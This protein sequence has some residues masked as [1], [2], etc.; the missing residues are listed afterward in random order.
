MLLPGHASSSRD[1]AA[2]P[3]RSGK[4]CRRGQAVD[5]AA[6]GIG[7]SMLTEAPVGAKLTAVALFIDEA[8]A[9]ARACPAPAGVWTCLVQG[10]AVGRIVGE[11]RVLDGLW[12]CG[13]AKVP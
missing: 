9:Q 5:D 10:A 2:A 7:S 6:N 13:S 3:E 12:P 11:H 8:S 4:S 1:W